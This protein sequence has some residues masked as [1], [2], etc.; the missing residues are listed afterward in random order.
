MILRRQIYVVLPRG[1][2]TRIR[3]DGYWRWLRST[4]GWTGR[5]RRGLAAWIARRCGTGRIASMNMAPLASSMSNQRLVGRSCRWSNKR[6]CGS[7]WRPA[8]IR[9]SMAWSAGDAW[10]CSVSWEPSSASICRQWRLV[11]SSSGLASRISAPARC[12]PH[13]MRRRLRLLKKLPRSGRRGCEYTRT[14]NADRGL[15]PGRD[16]RWTEERSGL[17]VG[18][19]GLA[20]APAKGS[21]LRKC[22]SFRRSL[23][24][25]Q[26]WNC[27]HHAACRHRSHAEA[28]R[29]DQ[30]G[31]CTRRARADHS[32]QGGMAHHPQAQAPGQPH[33]GSAAARLPGTECGGKHLA[34][35][36]PDLSLQSR[37]RNLHRNPRRLPERMAQPSQRARPHR[38]HCQPR[39][40]LHRLINSKSG[41]STSTC[42]PLE[43]GHCSTQSACLKRA[44]TGSRCLLDHVVGAGEESRRDFEAKRLGSLE[45]DP[46]IETRGLVKRNVSRSAALQNLRNLAGNSAVGVR[47]IDRIS[48]QSPDLDE[49]AIRIDCGNRALCNQFDERDTIGDVL[50]F[51]RYHYRIYLVLLQRGE[52]PAVFRFVKGVHESGC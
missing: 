31:C 20:T 13:R 21:A 39:L 38:V 44:M 48:H 19:K 17:P 34:I 12:T 25:P 26:Y 6:H 46:K 50:A 24:G 15:V 51:V 27:S 43:L 22:L 28:C 10:T 33:P 11:A 47:K 29:R 36:A 45:V 35:P 37:V 30:S 1:R 14:G 3:C 41:I 5:R 8:P 23:S 2:R 32:R 16:A 49:F 18:Q 4:M 9:R 40:G 7:W 42:F 52:C